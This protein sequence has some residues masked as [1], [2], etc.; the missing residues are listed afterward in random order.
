MIDD[1]SIDGDIDDWISASS[2]VQWLNEPP[3]NRCTNNGALPQR[4]NAPIDTQ[5]IDHR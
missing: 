5:I 4:P 3:M 2:F 1:L